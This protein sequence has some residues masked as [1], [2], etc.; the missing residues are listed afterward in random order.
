MRGGVNMR[1][2]R[3][4]A[5]GLISAL[6]LN[7]M[8]IPAAATEMTSV[9][10]GARKTTALTVS[11]TD[12]ASLATGSDARQPVT[13]GTITEPLV[14]GIEAGADLPDNET[15]LAGYIEKVMYGGTEIEPLGEYGSGYLEGAPLLLYQRLKQHI[16]KIAA[17]EETSTDISIPTSGMGLSWTYSELGTS[18]E[19]GN[20]GEVIMG[21]LVE[22]ISFDE[23]ISCLLAD[24][25]YELYWYEKTKGVGMSCQPSYT[26]TGVS[27]SQLRFK[28]TVAEAYAG[29][30]ENTVDGS[31]A[32]STKTAAANAQKIVTAHQNEDDYRKLTSYREEICDLVT[33]D[34]SVVED[35]STPYG[36]PWQLVY[37]F[38]GNK[39]TN[40]VCE[41]YSKAFQYL[42]DLSAFEGDITCYTV[43]GNL[44]NA[45]GS[46]AG[47]HM[48]NIVT[49]EDGKNYLVDVTNCDGEAGNHSVGYPDKL[50]LVG[51]AEE[52]SNRWFFTPNGYRIGYKYNP[53]IVD[54]YGA[55]ILDLS[56][57]NYHAKLEIPSDLKAVYGDKLSSVTLPEGWTWKDGSVELNQVGDHTFTAH[58]A[59]DTHNEAQD[60]DL[61]VSVSA[62]ELKEAWVAIT[63]ADNLMYNGTAHRPTVTIHDADL[64]R[65]LTEGTDYTVTYSDNVNAG[66]A[67]IVIAARGNYKGS[68]TRTFRIQGV[69]IGS[70]TVTVDGSFTY[71]GEAHTP[72]PRVSLDGR[73][74]VKGTDYTVSYRNNI[75]AGTATITITAAGNY[76]GSVSVTFTIAKAGSDAAIPEDLAAGYGGILSDVKLPQGWTWVDGSVPTGDAGV[77]TFPAVFSGDENHEPGNADLRVTVTARPLEEAWVAVTGAENLE[78]N[79]TAHRPAVTV[80]D[81]GLNRT[82]TEGTEYTVTYADNTNAGTASISIKGIG[83]YSGEIVHKFNIAPIENPAEVPAGLKAVYGDTFSSVTLPEGWTWESPDAPVGDVG[84]VTAK[85]IIAA[86]GN[87]KE[88]EKTVTVEVLARKLE[89]AVI[90]LSPETAVYTGEEIRPSVRIDGGI[91]PGEDTY[92][93]TYENNVNAGTASV[94]LKGTKNCTG[95]AVKE[96]TIQKATPRLTIGAG[97]VITK[98]TGDGTFALDASISNQGTLTYQSSNEAVVTVD[99]TGLVTIK[100]AGRAV[101]TV[102]YAGDNNY[103]EVSGEVRVTIET[104]FSGSPKP[105]TGGGGGG[106]YRRDDSGSTAGVRSVP[107][108]Y[109]GPTQKIG[110]VTVPNYVVPGSWSQGAD[111]AWSFTTSAGKACVNEWVAAYNQYA[112][113]ANGQM[114]FD[115]FR[116]DA[117]GHMLTG[118]YTDEKGDVYYLNPLSDNTRGR[119]IT[120]WFQIDG[121]W[122]Y[123]NELPDGTRGKLLTS[124]TTP[125]GYVVDANGAWT[126]EKTN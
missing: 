123:F 102:A 62:R 37:V 67:S 101:I 122:Y 105:A 34:Y 68:V 42:C 66:T 111:G 35:T 115:W 58:Y 79:G 112:D 85:A 103:N 90:V 4:L 59:G 88:T 5:W 24:C 29:T 1:R 99:A 96:F 39:S 77:H 82:L 18:P 81:A 14:F 57:T 47:G 117:D 8:V 74:L 86:T 72:E 54:L 46:D 89:E 41:G 126:G 30:G 83:N 124:T 33:Y 6:V 9:R 10:A 63:G 118:W 13:G 22:T 91:L 97:T 84:T 107:A 55:G 78:Y 87:Y 3:L 31:K 44:L 36:D 45:D 16:I 125:D 32:R 56:D 108:G 15:L 21:K 104:T 12:A 110:N 64:N 98:K 121:K 25:P 60:M 43:D 53:E 40:V 50:F 70:A 7:Q 23:V 28:F 19:S 95:E 27:I 52:G 48:W 69:P 73:T 65:T 92:T 2:C 116:F 71:T 80:R 61:V 49:M 17:G 51:G 119:M 109:D 76:S 106:S 20:F 93:V 113:L 100:S 94:I 11:G 114:A 120:G 75:N 26:N 38:D